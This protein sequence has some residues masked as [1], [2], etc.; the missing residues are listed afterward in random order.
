MSEWF[1]S[2]TI[3]H[4]P[5]YQWYSE[6]QGLTMYDSDGNSFPVT[7]YVDKD[8]NSFTAHGQYVDSDGNTFTGF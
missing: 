6:N 5:Y 8:G 3:P 4:V 2:Q 1:L 7:Q